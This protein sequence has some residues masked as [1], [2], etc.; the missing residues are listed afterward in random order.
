ALR[1]AYRFH[2]PRRGEIVVFKAPVAAARD[3]GGQGGI[4]V[5]RLVGLPG[6]AVSERNGHVF[7][8]G[9]RLAEPYV[10]APYRDSMT[11]TWPRISPSH[12]FMLGDNRR[13]SC[14]SRVW[15]TVP[16]N[17]LIGPA[18]LT[19]WPPTRLADRSP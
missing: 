4:F 5:K 3:C 1:L 7:I 2:A 13:N 16:R 8:N 19:Y 15:G 18:V 12:F 14:D 9:K 10:K 6:D 11:A 17:A